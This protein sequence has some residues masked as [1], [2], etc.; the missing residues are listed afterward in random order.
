MTYYLVLITYHLLHITYHTL[1][2]TYHYHYRRAAWLQ[3]RW[4]GRS[5]NCDRRPER[6]GLEVSR[7]WGLRGL[8]LR[9]EL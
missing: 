9:V 7:L 2:L 4:P 5:L 8:G 3:D 1:L 6:V